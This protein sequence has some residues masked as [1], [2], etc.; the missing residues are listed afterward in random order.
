MALQ[1]I[2]KLLE[3]RL[4][5]LSPS[6]PIAF[7]GVTFKPPATKYLRT[8]INFR[9]PD[10]SVLG[11]SYYRE[12]ISFNVYVVDQVNI[13]TASAFNTAEAIRDLFTKGTSL[14]EA[15]VTIKIIQTPQI[16]GSTIA[17]ERL[18]VPVL[19]SAIAEVI[20]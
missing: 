1:T 16:Q 18:V 11:S 10:D 19:I 13:G 4:A 9:R 5:T 7:E 15:N 2:R 14:S 17:S 12:I 6:L 3:S 20:S 8:N